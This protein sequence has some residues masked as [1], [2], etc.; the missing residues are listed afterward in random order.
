LTKK[1]SVVAACYNESENIEEL[2]NRVIKTIK[3]QQPNNGYEII[4]VDNA[5]TDQSF[6]VF[7][8]IVSM[9]A[10]VKVLLMSRN[11]GSSQPSFFAGLTAAIGDC[12]VMLDGDLQ[13]PPEV[14]S[15]FIEQWEKG[16]DVVYGVRKKRRGSILRRIGYA[17]FYRVF[18]IL[19]YLD[20]PLDAGDF[21]LLDRKVVGVIKNLPEKDIYI[22]GLRAWTGFKQIGVEYIRDDRLR[23]KT[24]N[25]FLA[26]F[27]WAK[28]AIVNFSYKPLEYIS[29]LAIAAVFVTCI[30]SMVYIYWHFRYGAPKGF[31][32]LLMMMFI[33]NTIQLLALSVIGEYLIRIF[34]EVKCRPR[35]LVSNVLQQ[36]NDSTTKNI[37]VA[38]NNK[39]SHPL[40]QKN[41][42]DT[43]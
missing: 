20:I 38:I 32:T 14:I 28:K 16:F 18:K 42:Q 22:R 5:S 19:S 10:N 31:S 37:N 39:K 41:I 11:F 25:S 36:Q 27:S 34:Q 3:E 24:S 15:S 29:K 8:K 17:S 23:G 21:C 43:R 30:A 4:F 26:N 6:K 7:E 40:D 12:V 9:D 35:Y 1:I 33:F 13:D 2:Y